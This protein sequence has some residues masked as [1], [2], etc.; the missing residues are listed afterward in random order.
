MK[1]WVGGLLCAACPALADGSLVEAGGQVYGVEPLAGGVVLISPDRGDEIT[2]MDDCL[3]LHPEAG[4]GF[5]LWDAAGFSVLFA[6]TELRFAGPPPL[7][8]PDCGG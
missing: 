6:D 3:A 4:E 5:W 2:L 1:G 7:V 8:A